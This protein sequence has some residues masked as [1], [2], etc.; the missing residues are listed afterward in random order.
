MTIRAICAAGLLLLATAA[1]PSFAGDYEEGLG[2]HK[3]GNY[4]QSL[5]LFRRA[6]EQGDARAQFALAS[7]YGAGL[8]APMNYLEAH[9]WV[10][11]AEKSGLEE[12]RTFRAQMEKRMPPELLA[13]ALERERQQTTPPSPKPSVPGSGPAV[14]S[15]ENAVSNSL[16]T[17]RA[18]WAR[19][20]ANAYLAAY[21]P[22]FKIADGIARPK[23]EVRRR[24]RIARATHIMVRVTDPVMRLAPDGSVTV[25]FIQTYQSNIFKE[26]A[27]KTLVFANYGGNWLIREETSA[28]R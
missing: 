8:G 1:M 22:D 27:G 17:W 23:W 20:D 16:E 6:A 14:A 9:K 28:P 10:V 26:T 4:A 25:H 21:A 15:V 12:V 19:R 5:P 18:A 3:N 7:I 13:Q 2:F 24:E 11:L